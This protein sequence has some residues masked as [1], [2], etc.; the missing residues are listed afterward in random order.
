MAEISFRPAVCNGGL[1]NGTH[2]TI[3]SVDILR[4]YSDAFELSDGSRMVMDDPDSAIG[5]DTVSFQALLT[6][7]IPE[8]NT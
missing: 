5:I 1:E 3:N 2:V 7:G 6:T 4:S 8:I